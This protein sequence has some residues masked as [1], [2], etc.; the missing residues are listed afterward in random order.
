M[1]TKNDFLS[2]L[3]RGGQRLHRALFSLA[4]RRSLSYVA[5]LV[6]LLALAFSV[7]PGQVVL[8]AGPFTVN[9]T[10]DT[11]DASLGN[12]ACAD[13][14]GQC[15]LR[16]AIE[17]A[18]ASGGATTISLPSGTYNL[19]LGELKTGSAVGTNI[20]L[21]GAGAGTTIVNQTDGV[22]RVFN[23]D[24]GFHGNV[25]LTIQN[26]TIQNGVGGAGGGGGGILDGDPGDVL[27]LTNVVLTNNQTSSFN[28][29][30]ISFTGGGTLNVQNSV[31]TNNSSPTG[32]GGAIHF[33]QT[34]AGAF[35]IA[36]STFAGNSALGGALGGQGGAIN[37]GCNICSPFSISGSTFTNNTA[38]QVGASG[39]QGGAIM[40]GSGALTFNFNRVVGNHAAGGGTGIYHGGSDAVTATNNWWGCNGGPGGAGCDTAVNAAGT[41]TTNPWIVLGNTASPNPILVNQSTTL[42]ASFLQNSAGTPL[43]VSNLGVL[44]GLPITFNN[45]VLGSLSGTQTTI[46]SNG[47]ATATFTAGNAI[48]TGH[49][50]AKV[51]NGTATANIAIND[52]PI[53][54]LSATDDSPTPLGRSTTLTASLVAGSDVIY[55][56]DLG[57]GNAIVSGNPVTHTY[58]VAGTFTAIVTATNNLSSMTATTQVTITEPITYYIYLPLVMRNDI[59]AVN[60]TGERIGALGDSVRASKN[61]DDTPAILDHRHDHI[62]ISFA[63]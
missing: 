1:I 48:G 46:Q 4:S 37:V 44:I 42:T 51:D 18:T 12:G 15:S 9:T 8:A 63:M 25:T 29:G 31:F 55:Q 13:S 27:N 43:S 19:S 58:G 5:V 6:L 60:L 21:S 32:N 36:N 49:A 41:L 33:L 52:A 59:G 35:T 10:N 34:Q 16:A 56:W 61:E 50:D 7:M 3:A 30:A 40:L 23:V 45:S 38:V 24:Y 39:G 17:E 11:H 54:G 20:T 62:L 47:T 22:N 57:D 2:G 28:G 14:N 26:V 53:T